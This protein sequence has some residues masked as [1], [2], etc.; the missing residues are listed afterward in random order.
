MADL[1]RL[2][3]GRAKRSLKRSD[4]IAEQ[5]KRWI[6]TEKMPPGTRLPQEKELLTLFSGSKGTIRE[7]LKSLEVQGLIAVRT[8]PAGGPYVAEVSFERSTELLRNYLHFQTINAQ[9][10]YAI[11]KAVEVELAANVVGRLTEKDFQRLEEN[12][13][14]CADPHAHDNSEVR[15]LELDFHVILANRCDNPLLA[16]LSRFLGDLLRDFLRFK[17]EKLPEFHT[18]TESNVH[19]H[20]L[21]LDAYRANDEQAVRRIMREHMEEAESKMLALEGYLSSDLLLPV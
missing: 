15:E 5:I 6:L 12:I 20:R 3:A 21:L 11:R 13:G 10:V 2:K 16:F 17:R 4:M 8:G 9:Q 19:F 14:C 1:E 18:F 7:A